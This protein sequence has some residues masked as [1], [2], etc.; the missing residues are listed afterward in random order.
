M[1]KRQEEKL[2]AMNLPKKEEEAV[3]AIVQLL[4]EELGSDDAMKIR[5]L[6]TI[7]HYAQAEGFLD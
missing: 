3:R 4:N 1:T 6:A 2:R 5:V 7:N